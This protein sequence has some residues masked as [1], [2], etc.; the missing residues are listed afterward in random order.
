MLFNLDFANSTIYSFFFSLIIDMHFLIPATIAQ[1]F[2]S[3]AEL[4]ILIGI[5]SNEA[6][7]EIKTHPVTA[8]ATILA[9]ICQTNC[10][11]L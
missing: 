8:E 10:S 1:V 4:V 5:P 6:K 9:K 2:N 7:A 3:V 11:F